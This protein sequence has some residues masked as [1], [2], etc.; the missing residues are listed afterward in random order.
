MNAG[1]YPPISP[2]TLVRTTQEDEANADSWTEEGKKRRKWG[3]EGEVIAHH[4]SHGLCYEVK[5]KDGT[6]GCYDPT[7]LTIHFK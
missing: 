7:E 1:K 3:V 5:H 4:D 2:G 6:V